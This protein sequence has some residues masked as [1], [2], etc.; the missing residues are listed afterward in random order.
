M[1][2]FQR[3][4]SRAIWLL[5][6]VSELESINSSGLRTEFN[7]LRPLNAQPWDLQR[8]M[9]N[10]KKVETEKKQYWKVHHIVPMAEWWAANL[11]R[12]L[13]MVPHCFSA[14]SPRN[15]IRVIPSVRCDKLHKLHRYR[16]LKYPFCPHKAMAL[17]TLWKDLNDTA[18]K[19]VKYEND[20]L[21]KLRKSIVIY[22]GK[23]GKKHKVCS[24]TDPC[25]TTMKS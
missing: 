18:Q 25:S 10:G 8:Q 17:A 16:P 5:T 22:K 11:N 23:R 4:I 3:W 1:L 14:G 20:K 7:S 6:A 9:S 24:A 15:R 2:L 21:E 12:T 13:H 19:R